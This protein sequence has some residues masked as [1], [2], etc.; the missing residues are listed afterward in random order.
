MDELDDKPES[1]DRFWDPKLESLGEFLDQLS[2]DGAMDLEELD[3]FFTALHCCPDDV[4]PSEFLPEILGPGEALDNE[5]LFPDVDSARLF[6]ELI[7]HHWDLVGDALNAEDFFLPLLLEDDQGNSHGNNWAI[8]FLRGADM[9][10]ES[11]REILDD[12]D[13]K[14]GWFAP[15]FALAH[16]ED[17][18]PELRTNNEPITDELREKLVAGIAVAVREIYEYFAPQRK[19]KAAA[20]TWQERFG[21]KKPKIGRNDPCYCGSGKKYK[22]C[23]GAIQVN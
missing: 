12:E 16:E 9:R 11:W 18:D 5:E 8:G 14:A 23:C 4:P 19:L 22:H 10:Q 6:M 15:V 1:L 17:P 13:N 7:M 3:G 20:L 21:S 2:D